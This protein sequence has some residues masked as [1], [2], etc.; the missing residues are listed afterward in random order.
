MSY[1]SLSEV[2]EL[3]HPSYP[4]EAFVLGNAMFGQDK[5]HETRNTLLGGAW[6]TLYEDP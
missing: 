6:A 3:R 5:K 1:S 4:C 2:F